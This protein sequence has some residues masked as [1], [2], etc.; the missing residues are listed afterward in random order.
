MKPKSGFALL[1]ATFGLALG[2]PFVLINSLPERVANGLWVGGLCA[3]VFAVMAI[4]VQAARAAVR[5]DASLARAVFR[6]A[7]PF[8]LGVVAVLFVVFVPAGR[9]LGTFSIVDGTSFPGELFFASIASVA[10]LWTLASAAAVSG[11]AAIA[12]RVR[13][14]RTAS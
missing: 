13:R 8:Y 3:F 9:A 10:A 7:V 4:Q 11:A 6:A 2:L 12:R 5:D 14:T 1:G